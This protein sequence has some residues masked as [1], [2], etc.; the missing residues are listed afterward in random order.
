MDNAEK[1]L[2]LLMGYTQ[3]HLHDPFIYT[4]GRYGSEDSEGRPLDSLASYV[5]KFQTPSL[6]EITKQKQKHTGAQAC[7]YSEG[8]IVATVRQVI[9]TCSIMKKKATDP[10]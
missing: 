4:T 1:H 2:V 9:I 8:L 10:K 3:Q 5:F 6:N 7:K